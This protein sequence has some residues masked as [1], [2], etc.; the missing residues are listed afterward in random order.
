MARARRSSA[1][2]TKRTWRTARR[3]TVREGREAIAELRASG[4][5]IPEFCRR[6]RLKVERVQKWGIRLG[7]AGG[8]RKRTGG[9]AVEVRPEQPAPTRWVEARIA[10]AERDSSP[11]RQGVSTIRV[12]LRGGDII[13]VVTANGLDSEWLA[14]L[15][16]GVSEAQSR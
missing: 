1:A 15:V 3:W 4:A 7:A 6:H 9:A 13:D 2:S 14:R 8:T 5:T 11:R 16:R 12:H 10:G